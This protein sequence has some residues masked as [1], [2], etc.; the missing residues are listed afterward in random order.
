MR[1][2]ISIIGHR[3]HPEVKYA[4]IRF[5]QSLRN[6]YAFPIRVPIYLRP[7]LELTNMSGENC[8]ASF[9]WPRDSTV[10]PY[11]R[12][13]TGEY[14]SEKKECGRDDDVPPILSSTQI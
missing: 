3:G 10:E 6:N 14:E 7:E 5:A 12:I 4:L 13:T 8:S 1:T 11:R 9:F 2:G